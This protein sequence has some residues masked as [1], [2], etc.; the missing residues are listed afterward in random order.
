MVI[1]SVLVPRIKRVRFWKSFVEHYRRQ[2]L[3]HELQ[4]LDAFQHALLVLET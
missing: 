3:K 4:A 2:A 1:S